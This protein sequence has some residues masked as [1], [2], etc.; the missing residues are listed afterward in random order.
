MAGIVMTGYWYAVGKTLS[1]W[2]AGLKCGDYLV[3]NDGAFTVPYQS[4]P[5]ALLTATYLK[6]VSDTAPLGAGTWGSSVE[7]VIPLTVTI[8]GTPTNVIVP[9]VIGYKYTSKGQLVRPND[10]A[11]SKTQQGPALGMDRRIHQFA[12]QLYDTI[13]LS[14]GVKSGATYPC[15]FTDGDGVHGTLLNSATGFTGIFRQE[16]QADYD[17]DNMIYWEVTDPYPVTVISITG[18][19]ETQE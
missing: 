13:G 4:D 11:A 18:F 1:V 9:G 15:R 14:V 8:G 3:G 2:L 17:F 16:I 7:F 19:M 5:D 12:M 6:G 10:P